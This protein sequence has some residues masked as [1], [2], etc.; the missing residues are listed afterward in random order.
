MLKAVGF[1]TEN[2]V[3]SYIPNTAESAFYGLIKGVE[4][5]I[6]NSKLDDIIEKK[7][8]LTREELQKIINRRPRVEKIAVKDVK[9][10]TFITEDAGRDDLVGHVYD[11]TYGV[12]EEVSI[13]LWLLTTR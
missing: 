8:S 7:D 2:T 11:V 1:N 9:L 5:F 10:R 3:F 12:S 4:D 13:I 6:N